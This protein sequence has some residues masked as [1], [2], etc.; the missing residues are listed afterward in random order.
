SVLSLQKLDKMSDIFTENQN[1]CIIT[2]ASKGFGC[3]LVHQVRDGLGQISESNQQMSCL[4]QWVN[5]VAMVARQEAVNKLDYVLLIN[6]AASSGAISRC[7]SFTDIAEVNSYLS[8]NV[9]SALAP[10]A[11]ILQASPSWGLY[12]TP[13]QPGGGCSLCWLRRDQMLKFSA[14][15]QVYTALCT[16]HRNISVLVEL[17]I[18]KK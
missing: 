9:S 1:I 3:V 17:H 16:G 15:L 10:T 13:Q 11:G 8:L 5:E 14:A 18:H 2:G 4:F 7:A 12:C 6:N